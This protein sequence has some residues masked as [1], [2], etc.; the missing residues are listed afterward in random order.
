MNV[1]PRPFIGQSV[2]R[3]ED[4]PLVTGQGRFAADI[5]FS[6]E[7]HMRVVRSTRAHAKLVSI[8][9]NA[10]LACA[11][12]FAVWTAA[13]ITEI[14]VIDFREGPNEALA[15]Y[16][17]PVLAATEVRYVGEPI[18][19]VFA[20]N[21]YIAEDAAELVS[22]EFEELSPVLVAEDAP[23]DFSPGH[24]TE[25]AVIRQGYGD[26]DAAFRAAHAIIKLDLSIGRHSGVPFE[27]RGAVAWFDANR[28]VLELHG[29]AKV[30]HK[31][32]E[33]LARMLGRPLAGVHL[34]ESCVG[35]GFGVRGELYPEDV[36]VCVAALH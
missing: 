15:P 35:G 12:V 28:D 25:A 5:A 7:V 20:E 19:V 4:L 2:R 26:V 21:S 17:Q 10:A 11:G 8:D 31:N 14:P 13:D 34:Y 1:K 23:Q 33:A 16:R 36:L 24:S 6:R 22:V 18:A 27:T 9:I 32:R 30:P 29:A 3:L